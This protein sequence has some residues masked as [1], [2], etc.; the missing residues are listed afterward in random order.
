[1]RGLISQRF[2]KAYSVARITLALALATL[3]QVILVPESTYAF[4]AEPTVT[5]LLNQQT[6][7]V[8]GDGFIL[9]EQRIRS[10]EP[11]D[12][13]ALWPA[14][15]VRAV[16]ADG[17]GSQY[18]ATAFDR[19]VVFIDEQQVG[20]T[21]T[22]R[23]NIVDMTNRSR[24]AT[25]V[26]ATTTPLWTPSI[27]EGIL[28]WAQ[29]PLGSR[30]IY[31]LR[32]DLDGN[33]VP[34]VLEGGPVSTAVVLAADP[35]ADVFSPVLGPGRLVFAS[36][37]SVGSARII[38]MSVSADS[39]RIV[40]PGGTATLSED[41]ANRDP[42][43]ATAGVLAVWRHSADRV[44]IYDFVAG[45]SVDA[46]SGPG[47]SIV[48][49][50]STDGVHVAWQAFGLPPG[51]QGDPIHQVF[52]RDTTGAIFR[53]SPV[54]AS[55][56]APALGRGI[57]AWG[58]SR[59]THTGQ[60][61]NL[62]F[63]SLASRR[64]QGADRFETAARSSEL[65]FPQGSEHVLI[66]TGHNWPDALGGSAL[67]GVLDAPILLVERDSVPAATR[68]EIARLGARRALILGGTGAVGAR[69]QSQLEGMGVVVDRL[70]GDNRY[71]TAERIATRVISLLG[72]R[73]DGTLFLA[74]GRDFPDALSA[75]PIAVRQRWPVVLV[76]PGATRLGDGVRGLVR[77][78]SL[79]IVLGGLG[80]VPTSVEDEVRA[81][82]VPDVVRLEGPDRY[83]TAVAIARFAT[84][85]TAV[86]ERHRWDRVGIS[87]GTRFPD[88]LSG[89][90]LQGRT[91]SVMMLTRPDVLPESVAVTLRD[92][93]LAIDTVVF[94]GGTVAVNQ[95]VRDSVLGN[96]R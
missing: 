36:R 72:T 93:A 19:Y 12:L 28:T 71:Q 95:N 65:A 86:R 38:S 30:A 32:L 55:Q 26:S 58:D 59:Q 64:V 57:L 88:A 83:D 80:A 13:W 69:V 6:N 52:M 53:A 34:D 33:G 40:D 91:G 2:P 96:V 73:H 67:A 79:V 76:D 20:Q 90:V 48:V 24:R 62:A 3:L 22:F 31:G 94:F 46:T 60:T 87:T 1:M 41:T 43:P 5:P 37:L 4:L 68:A 17:P 15:G 50:P 44:R 74:T 51:S 7:P 49:S 84:T 11:A 8:L 82:G 9:F 75:A 81:L 23:L 47:W 39:T 77:D 21:N 63:V 29:G 16:V 25:I 54:L 10:D 89:G 70:G 66:A 42:D 56:H 78:S 27:S 92:N 14:T 35:G 85:H 18:A 61:P 45:T